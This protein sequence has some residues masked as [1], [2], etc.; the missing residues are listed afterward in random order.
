MR[1]LTKSHS[2]NVLFSYAYVATHDVGFTVAHGS[3]HEVVGQDK[4]LELSHTLQHKTEL[5]AMDVSV[6]HSHMPHERVDTML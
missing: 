4:L 6:M 5:G 2:I 1:K 3:Q